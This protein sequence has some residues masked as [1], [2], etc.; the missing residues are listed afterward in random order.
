MKSLEE[1][2]EGI[3]E[4]D[5]ALVPLLVRRM[6]LV[7]EVAAAKRASGKAVNDPSREQA[8]LARV[9][10]AAGESF[11]A[12]VKSVFT[13]MFAVSKAHQRALLAGGMKALPWN[14][15]VAGLGLIGGS[16]YKASLRAGYDTVGLHH[17]D[18]PDALREADLV[19]VCLPPEAIVPW[20]RDHAEHF[21]RG[22]LVVDICGVK[23][24]IVAAMADVPQKGWR[25]VGG[26]PMAGRE[27]S[28]YA[29][30]TADLFVGAS[31]I[32]TP[33]DGLP[34]EDVERLAAYFK[35]VGFH[36][37]VITTPA[38]HDEMIAFTSQLCHV[39]ATAYA[40]DP[41]VKDAIGFSAGSY[42]NM[43]RIATQDDAIWSALFLADRT[44]LLDVVDG[45]V[46]R[47][48]EFRD[49]L[50]SADVEAVRAIIAEG[51]RAKRQELLERLRGDENA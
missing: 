28:G 14:V 50:A 48:G 5:R 1:I 7:A 38:R 18:G 6:E 17:G 22:A 41:R 45:F 33:P 49:A 42:A 29:N 8:I 16:F 13:T 2:R 47:L 30:S 34:A 27:V 31:M 36:Q 24:P 40:R 19:L 9:G 10:A 3:D 35:S 12:P 23:E 32:L 20:I 11:A 51:T 15:A 26:H 21:K 46:G 39:I 44:A 25:F 4:V 43:T 37:T